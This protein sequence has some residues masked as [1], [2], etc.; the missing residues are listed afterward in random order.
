MKCMNLI[1]NMQQSYADDL[2]CQNE[3]LRQQLEGLGIEPYGG[4]RTSTAGPPDAYYSEPSREWS[5]WLD[6]YQQDDATQGWSPWP[7]THQPDD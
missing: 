5:P 7:D 3:R 4:T 1:M 6:P 2:K